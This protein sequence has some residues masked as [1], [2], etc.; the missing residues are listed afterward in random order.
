MFAQSLAVKKQEEACDKIGRENDDDCA[1]CG[2]G[3][4]LVLCDACP[5]AYHI[6]MFLSLTVHVVQR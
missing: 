3:G 5:R 4:D 2:D 6:G 1:E